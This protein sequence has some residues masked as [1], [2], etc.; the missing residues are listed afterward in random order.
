MGPKSRLTSAACRYMRS[1]AMYLRQSSVLPNVPWYVVLSSKLISAANTPAA[2]SV[3]DAPSNELN[4]NHKSQRKASNAILPEP[5]QPTQKLATHD[6]SKTA[7]QSCTKPNQTK[8]T[9]RLMPGNSPKVMRKS[10]IAIIQITHKQRMYIIST[11]THK[12][13]T[14]HK[15]LADKIKII[16]QISM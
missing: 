5:N 16:L 8:L 13:T 10:D 15:L 14:S 2:T 11:A 12:F 6:N 1:M 9:K 4:D 7:T 3:N